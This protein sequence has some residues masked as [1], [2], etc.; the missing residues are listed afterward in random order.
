MA[1]AGSRRLPR[2]DR[3]VKIDDDQ[4]SA[5]YYQLAYMLSRFIV[6]MMRQTY[7]EFGGDML[8]TLV[9]GEIA[10]R[11]LELFF[12]RGEPE[13]PESVLNDPRLQRSLLR[14]CNALSISTATGIPRETVRRRVKRLR[15]LGL[16][17]QDG[18]GHLYVTQRTADR[19]QRLTRSTLEDLLPIAESLR[20]LVRR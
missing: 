2:Q 11:N 12:G 1:R 18:R 10:S 6:P 5:H 16:I 17:D 8:L 7:R 9:L 20:A 3:E 13:L 19:F 4:F 14:P 15:D